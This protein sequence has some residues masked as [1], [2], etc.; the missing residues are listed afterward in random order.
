MASSAVA[1]GIEVVLVA[2]IAGEDIGCTEV[3]LEATV[4]VASTEVVALVVG[5]EADVV[6]SFV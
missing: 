2:S 5:I 6:R 1:V 4:R 3:D